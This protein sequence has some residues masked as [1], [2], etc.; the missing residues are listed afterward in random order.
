MRPSRS[1]W[2]WRRYAAS[3]FNMTDGATT[4]ACSDATRR[5]TS[6]Q[7]SQMTSALIRWPK[8]GRTRELTDQMLAAGLPL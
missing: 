1:S 2:F 8:I 3:F 4:P 7:C 6:F 5:T